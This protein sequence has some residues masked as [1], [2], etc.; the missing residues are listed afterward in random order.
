MKK[1][2]LVLLLL[3]IPLN[4]QCISS[5]RKKMWAVSLLSIVSWLSSFT[6]SVLSGAQLASVSKEVCVPRAYLECPNVSCPYVHCDVWHMNVSRCCQA[7][8]NRLECQEWVDNGQL[9][10]FVVEPGEYY[11]ID[12]ARIAH[13]PILSFAQKVA[14]SVTAVIAACVA[15]HTY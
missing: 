7:V 6:D 10:F 11:F 9:D 13:P 3:A 1:L 4:S 14:G 5:F 12:G 2:L 15:G 8:E